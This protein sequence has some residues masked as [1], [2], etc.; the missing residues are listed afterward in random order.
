MRAENLSAVCGLYSEIAQSVFQHKDTR[1]TK[2][3]ETADFKND[4][5]D[6]QDKIFLYQ[7]AKPASSA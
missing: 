6:L 7:A 4:K 1:N 2:K 3:D 5:Q